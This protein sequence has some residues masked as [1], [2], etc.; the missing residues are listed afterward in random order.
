MGKSM[1]VLYLIKNIYY[2]EIVCGGQNQ[3]LINNTTTNN[4]NIVS[5][6]DKIKNMP[7]PP[8]SNCQN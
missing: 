7:P 5:V 6:L 3:Y 1:H 2:I 8:I 4:L